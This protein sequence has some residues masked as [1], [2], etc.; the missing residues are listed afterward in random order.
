MWEKLIESPV[1]AGRLLARPPEMEE[2]CAT[3]GRQRKP[4][5][6]IVWRVLR[7]DRE[8]LAVQVSLLW[9][10]VGA[11]LCDCCPCWSKAT[12]RPPPDES[13]QS[14]TYIC[15]SS[16]SLFHSLLDR[17]GF[18]DFPASSNSTIHHIIVLHKHWLLTCL[19]LQFLFPDI[20]TPAPST[21]EWSLIP[22]AS[23]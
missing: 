9:L 18:A 23:P 8:V 13:W 22:T 20:T 19:I 21:T 12:P 2:L 14:Y 17:P 15:P 4:V 1:Q 7:W 16:H 3:F 6:I 11:H 10:P 5:V